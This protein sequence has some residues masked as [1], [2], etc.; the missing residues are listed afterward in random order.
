[1]NRILPKI[2]LMQV[3]NEFV[4]ALK[5]MPVEKVKQIYGFDEF[6]SAK[7]FRILALSDKSALNPKRTWA[8]EIERRKISLSEL[9]TEL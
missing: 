7:D 6:S 4:V 2:R 9:P 5:T 8:E 1:M 3:H